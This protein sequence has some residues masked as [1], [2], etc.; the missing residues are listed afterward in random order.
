MQ[1]TS[2][3][4]VGK[5]VSHIQSSNRHEAFRILLEERV[6]SRVEMAN[7]LGL[8]KATIT[9]IINE[10]LEMGIVKNIGLIKGENGRSTN[11]LSLNIDDCA[12]ISA[13]ISR[14]Y[15]ETVVCDFYGNILSYQ[16]DTINPKAP[17]E[18]TIDI[19][20]GAINKAIRENED[21][22][23]L[24][25]GVAVPGPFIQQ[26]R[27]HKAIVTDFISL[28]QID[29]QKELQEKIDYPVITDHDANMA[30]LAEW[31]KIYRDSYD[32]RNSMVFIVVEYGIGAGII[33]NGKVIRGELGTAGEIGLMGI[34]F[35]GPILDEGNR[36]TLEY[37]A[38]NQST[39]RY[40]RERLFEFPDS[41]LTES[42]SISEI[43]SA[44][45]NENP[46]AI[47]AVE[48][49]AWHLG[50]GVANIINTLNPKYI[51]IGDRVPNN[52][53]YLEMVKASTRKMVFEDIYSDT[54]IVYQ[55]I[56]EHIVLKGASQMVL[57]EAINSL[58]I[59]SWL[60]HHRG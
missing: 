48:K 21:K 54:N 35:N 44:Y 10:F 5:N 27:R 34:N 39:K 28:Q 40:L 8:K 29:I 33:I 16:I 25:V 43:Y 57:D 30:A 56:G 55:K 9:N 22:K 59:I 6:I 18:H 11:G 42:S 53:R 3:F 38:S 37:Y 4:K 41:T 26:N 7:R 50:Y 58:E 46:L 32:S 23:I 15:T 19:I 31:K 2:K 17:I 51:V 13:R 47:Y 45:D 12:I 49:S 52:E 24:G 36:G 20:T 1:N 60:K 14:K